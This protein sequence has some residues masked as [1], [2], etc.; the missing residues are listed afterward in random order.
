MQSISGS[1]GGHDHLIVRR[2]LRKRREVNARGRIS[3]LT[4][5]SSTQRLQQQL[6]ALIVQSHLAGSI[7]VELLDLPTAI[8]EGVHG[9]GRSAFQRPDDQ[10]IVLTGRNQLLVFYI[11]LINGH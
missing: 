4:K 9:L 5:Q 1:T 11:H 6:G 7:E 2:E 3:E 10:A 8:I